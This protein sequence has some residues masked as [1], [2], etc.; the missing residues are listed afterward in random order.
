M[1]TQFTPCPACGAVGEVGSNCQFCGTA[2]ILKEGATLSEA[3][4]VK[5]RTVTPQQYAEKISIYH[6]VV[7][8]SSEISKVS[9]G[10]QEGLINL[11]GEL[12]YP[13]GNESIKITK[14]KI[15]QIG[16]KF[17]N[18]ET[19]E[20]VKSPYLNEFVLEKVKLL[21]DAI[22][23]DPSEKGCVYFIKQDGDNSCFSIEATG[24]NIYDDVLTSQL[25]F[26]IFF[27]NL[28]DDEII[29]KYE[30]LKSCDDFNLLKTDDEEPAL[31]SQYYILCGH[32]VER[33]VEIALR[34]L[35]Q[36][37]GIL[38]EDAHNHMECSWGVFGNEEVSTD[39][40][41]N[42]NNGCAGILALLVSVG[43]A[44]IYGLIELIG[45]LIA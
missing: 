33:C 26:N 15:V 40:A 18:L 36:V 43:G 19:F 29:S 2:I 27:G 34:I 3:R 37:D 11:N 35:C 44:S 5:Q 9:I 23:K 30:R 24:E 32:D 28:N 22:L 25:V 13:L 41:E 6:N 42:T 10:G 39:D 7:G 21:S 14:G 16:K 38:P 17:L 20:F 45:S 31:D 4:I 1:A 8:L 12:I